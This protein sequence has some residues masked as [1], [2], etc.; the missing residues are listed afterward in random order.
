MTFLSH[1]ISA[2]TKDRSLDTTPLKI[3]GPSPVKLLPKP[4]V[5]CPPR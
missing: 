4:L 5:H 2:E 3:N 1:R